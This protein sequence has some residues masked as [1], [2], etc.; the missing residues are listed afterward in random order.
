MKS[1]P[2]ILTIGFLPKIDE[3]TESKE[4]GSDQD[5]QSLISIDPE[6]EDFIKKTD[7]RLLKWI[8][9][10][11]LAEN[12]GKV[13]EYLL[14]NPAYP[15]RFEDRSEN[16]PDQ[17]YSEHDFDDPSRKAIDL[18]GRSAD[19]IRKNYAQNTSNA[20]LKEMI[21][22]M[23]DCRD[24]IKKDFEI[25]PR[26]RHLLVTNSVGDPQKQTL[27]PERMSRSILCSELKLG[28]EK[29]VITDEMMIEIYLQIKS[30]TVYYQKNMSSNNA[31]SG[32]TKSDENSG[33]AENNVDCTRRI[34]TEAEMIAMKKN[35]STD[36]PPRDLPA[37]LI[38]AR[39]HERPLG[40]IFSI[41]GNILNFGSR[42]NKGK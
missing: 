34:I 15:E 23:N 32:S 28:E 26:P 2:Q 18:T 24:K 31:V 10:Y 13:I 36:K 21:Q 20:K 7:T 12:D 30:E 27:Y 37:V 5:L 41:L 11:K 40:D 1:L 33:N 17:I 35:P 9:E 4:S 14:K 25:S 38:K 8:I 39:S 19:E 16:Y 29:K 3:E 6:K 22:A 42:E